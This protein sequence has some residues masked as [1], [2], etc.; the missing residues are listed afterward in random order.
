MRR[1]AGESH[2]MSR[3]D[4]VLEATC[5]H[6]AYGA[7][8]VLH[9][10][11]LRVAP[12]ETVALLGRN[13]SGKTTLLRLL[14][15]QLAPAGGRV[16]LGGVPLGRM[17]PKERARRLAVL[18]QRPLFIPG[19]SVRD[20]VLLG[21]YARLSWWGMYTAADRAAA[22]AALEEVGA[23][24]LAQRPMRELSGGEVQRVALARTLA[25]DTPL[26]LLDEL[27]AA[28]DAARAVALF[29]VLERR[30]RCGAAIV[31]AI[32]DCSLAALYAT[33]LAGL[34]KGTLLFDG[35]V[36][37]VFT[38]ENLAALYGTPLRVVAHP[39]NG[40]PQAL[41]AQT[42]GPGA[43]VGPVAAAAGVGGRCRS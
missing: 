31:M 18:A 11:D 28:L 36:T 20:F 25:Q 35:P 9:G 5:L 26:L 42:C 40:L 7:R 32:H 22:D 34:H 23:A 43:A 17:R 27:S 6:A 37:S 16:L 15:G 13:G 33:R 4:V 14:S 12:G 39:D 41:V 3:E 10:V 24:A 19:M 8:A 30:R 38:E 1:G 21:R 29:D 2:R